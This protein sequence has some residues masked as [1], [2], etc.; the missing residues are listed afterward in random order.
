MT[1]YGARGRLNWMMDD[2]TAAQSGPELDWLEAEAR[3]EFA[4]PS[5]PT[6]RK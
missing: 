6:S 1:A 2:I 5:S 3:T 4:H